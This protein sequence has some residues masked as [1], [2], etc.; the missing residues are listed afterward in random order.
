MKWGPDVKIKFD[1]H[2]RTNEVEALLK[3]NSN[4]D[5][6]YPILHH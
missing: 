3:L 5:K 2:K 6:L 4:H 1:S